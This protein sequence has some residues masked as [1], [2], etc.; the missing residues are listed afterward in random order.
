MRFAPNLNTWLIGPVLLLVL[1]LTNC[2]PSWKEVIKHGSVAQNEFYDSVQI[3]TQRRLIF[4][5]VNIQG[6][7]YRFL[8]DSGAPFSV[9]KTLQDKLSFKLLS[10]GHIIDSDNNRKEVDWVE[11]DTIQIGNI[12]FLNQTA[13]VADLSSNP[14]LKCLNIDGII[15]SNL[16]RHCNW[17]INQDEDLITMCSTI[18][19]DV[20]N[21][22][23]S[24]PFKT[25][26][27]YNIY[28]EMGFG[29]TVLQNMQID[30]G[31]NGSITL[32]NEKFNE[33]LDQGR[34]S[35]SLIEKGV[36]QTGIIGNPVE[37]SRQISLTDS[38]RFEYLGFDNTLV[39]TGK[40]GLVGN[41]VLARFIVAI[42][43]QNKRLLLR[44][45][46]SE[47]YPNRLYGFN[48]GYSSE[49]GI[50]IQSVIDDSEAYLKGIRPNMKVTRIDTLNF[51][52]ENDFC[53]Y[54]NHYSGDQ[55]TIEL[56][57]DQGKRLN[58]ELNRIDFLEE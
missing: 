20:I 42:D 54:V 44:N 1:V 38:L 52:L 27:Q 34:I 31:S 17:I 24:I 18:N 35:H 46:L 30:Y 37:I 9:S 2:S 12:T 40:S 5:T 16:M 49:N 7:P 53:D 33:L 29:N 57:T 55:V 36:Q 58:L 28:L 51:E 45:A 22:S 39:S 50:Y 56:L 19:D 13:F 21:G 8:F 32:L 25:D 48:A 10:R 15:G 23:T 3:E 11:V 6:N 47:P 14:I 41:K 26:E 43:W 4:L